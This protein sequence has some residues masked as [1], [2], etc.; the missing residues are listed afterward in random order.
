M[1][2]QLLGD[3]GSGKTLFATYM[4]MK[5]TRPVYSN[6]EIRIPNYRHL[7]PEI[8]VQIDEPA[9]VVVDEAY[10]WLESRTSGRHLNR[11]M[12]YNLFQQRK[13]GLDYVLTD[14]L[15]GTIDSRF[16]LM[17][18]YKIYCQQIADVGFHYTIYKTS[19]FKRYAPVSMV[20]PYKYAEMIYPFFDS[21]EPQPIDEEMIFNITEDKTE[22][23]ADT[24]RIASYLLSL[25]EGNS[26]TK[27]IVADYCLRNGFP[28]TFVE[29]T[30][31][32]IKALV[33]RSKVESVKQRPV[34]SVP[35]KLR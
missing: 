34:K 22:I 6:Y 15:E 33:M 13:K 27:G 5:E 1:L 18:N 2:I 3:V 12:S 9:L 16:R 19:A 25:Y 11:Y 32:R 4:A 7:T 21:W 10:R 20:L 23:I 8:L 14:Q 31:N 35:F 29:P 26:I 24:D 17:T 30:F 28:K